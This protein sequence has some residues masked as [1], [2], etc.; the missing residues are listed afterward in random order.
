M[1]SFKALGAVFG[2]VFILV[3]VVLA[4]MIKIG[5]IIMVLTASFGLVVILVIF[6]QI[7]DE[8]YFDN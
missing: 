4:M 6:A 2:V 1:P 3:L 7:I 5:Q 8:E